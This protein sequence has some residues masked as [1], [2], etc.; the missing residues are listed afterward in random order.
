MILTTTIIV[1]LS[2]RI[3]AVK[4]CNI[5][6]GLTIQQ[7]WCQWKRHWKIDF[8]TFETF[9]PLCQVTQLLESW[10]VRLE[11]KREDRI[12][13]QREMVELLSCLSHFQVNLKFGHVTSELFSDG[14]EMYKKVW[15]TCRVVVFYL[16]C[17]RH[18]HCHC[19]C[20]FVRSLFLV[21][22]NFGDGY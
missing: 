12:W 5:K 11:L 2:E 9:L 17:F 1:Y 6:R 22:K 21:V 3:I 18:S 20:N 16:L 7:P 14:K 13:V 10:E 15:W 19:C 4:I 8:V